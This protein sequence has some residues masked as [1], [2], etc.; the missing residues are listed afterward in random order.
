MIAMPKPTNSQELILLID[1]A[2][3][4]NP[5]G[6]GSSGTSLKIFANWAEVSDRTNMVGKVF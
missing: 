1:Q 3:A 6:G 4:S 5:D 2:L